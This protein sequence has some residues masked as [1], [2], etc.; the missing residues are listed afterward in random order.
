MTRSERL[1]KDGKIDI[2]CHGKSFTSKVIKNCNAV[3]DLRYIGTDFDCLYDGK[4]VTADIYE[5]KDGN[6]YAIIN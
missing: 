6:L 5:D 3:S 2:R 1:A 4:E